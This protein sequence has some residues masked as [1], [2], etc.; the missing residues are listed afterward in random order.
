MNTG[1]FS[2]ETK[3]SIYSFHLKKS[4]WLPLFLKKYSFDWEKRISGVN[5]DV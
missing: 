4:E 1:R 5:G 3:G 2:S